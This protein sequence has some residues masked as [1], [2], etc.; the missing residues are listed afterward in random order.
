MP[1]FAIVKSR[2]RL[3]RAIAMPTE[4][5]RSGDENWFYLVQNKI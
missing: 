5:W 3:T 1:G 2:P 4:L